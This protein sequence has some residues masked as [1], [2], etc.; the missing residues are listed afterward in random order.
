MI[1]VFYTMEAKDK[2]R[3]PIFYDEKDWIKYQEEQEIWINP[4]KVSYMTFHR[5]IGIGYLCIEDKLI[6]VSFTYAMRLVDIWSKK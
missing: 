4:D 1:Q 6:I 5:G 3:T 2:S